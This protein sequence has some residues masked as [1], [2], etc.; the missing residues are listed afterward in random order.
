MTKCQSFIPNEHKFFSKTN[1]FIPNFDGIV[2][3]ADPENKLL[4]NYDVEIMH[5]DFMPY[6]RESEEYLSEWVSKWVSSYYFY[7]VVE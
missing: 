4:V 1:S 3:E 7:L 2:R 6:T 5:T